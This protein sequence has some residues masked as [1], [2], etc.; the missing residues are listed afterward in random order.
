MSLDRDALVKELQ[1]LCPPDDYY[2]LLDAMD[3]MSDH[4]L[5]DLVDT[6]SDNELA[7]LDEASDSAGPGV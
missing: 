7:S 4:Q 3:D 6:F 1:R 5:Q 2:E